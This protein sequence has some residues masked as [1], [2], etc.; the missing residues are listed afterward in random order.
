MGKSRQ[1]NTQKQLN[2]S[3][4]VKSKRIWWREAIVSIFTVLVWLYCLTVIYFFIDAILSLN[5]KYPLLFK[6]VFKMTNMDIRNFFKIGGI[7]F[8]LIY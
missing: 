8:V 6:I 7:L 3:F 5:H 2:K 1:R 4:I